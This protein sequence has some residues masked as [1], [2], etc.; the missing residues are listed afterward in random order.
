MASRQPDRTAM[1]EAEVT[2]LEGEL[3]MLDRAW[4]R[5]HLLA[6]FG[7]FAIPAYFLF[8]GLVAGVVLFCTPA[9]IAT[10]AY[11]VGV[12]RYECRQLIDETRRELAYARQRADVTD[13]APVA[14][15]LPA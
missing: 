8:G 4:S 7:L 12:R 3:R 11:L 5:K 14:D 9:L 15:P 10:Q 6:A 1:L 2:R 13:A